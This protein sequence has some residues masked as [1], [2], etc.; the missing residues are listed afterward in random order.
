MTMGDVNRVL[1][2]RSLSV[3]LLCAW[4]V[5]GAHGVQQD[6]PPRSTPAP[7]A[8][9]QADLA[10]LR[11]GSM[12][13]WRGEDQ[14]IGYANM[15]KLA[16]TNLVRRGTQ[17]SPLPE[18]SRD[19]STFRY[20]VRGTTHDLDHFMNTLNVVGL[21]V[22]TDG[23][24]VLERYARGN[25]AETRWE[26]W[27][28]AK[29]VTS[30]LFGA[31][32][33]DG[34]I[35]TLDAQVSK[36]VPSLA[37]TSY[38]GVTLRHLLQMSSGVAWNSNLADPQSDVAQLPRL[39]KE[40]GLAAQVAYM[41]NKPRKAAPGTVFNY[42]TAEAD[43][44][45][46]VLQAA[47][48]RTLSD[49]LSE[50]IWRP[51]GMQSDGYWLTMGTSGL[52]RAGCCLSATLRDYGRLGQVA[53]GDGIAPDGSRLLPEGWI[54]ESTRPSPASR[55][56]GYFWWLRRNGSYF[57]SGSFGQHIEVAPGRRT[58]V[59]VQSYW[60]EAYNDELI[61]HNDTVVEALIAFASAKPGA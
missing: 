30:L 13:T 47:T 12:L 11:T 45:A 22:I 23:R 27:S 58:V 50:R 56:Y 3:V 6:G 31:A 17:P 1:S 36:Y 59:A 7:Q 4:A 14:R 8:A 38:D 33:R 26:S 21:L 29:S 16:P 49:Y 9:D 10:R 54:A 5:A 15:D 37:G 48:G 32:I 18:A 19:F 60:P 55:N 41:G 28:V 20:T 35:A 61:E 25:T 53:L 24:I 52:E 44:T 46:A 34:R 2:K 57:A 51:F 39:N 40:G 42:N 43:L